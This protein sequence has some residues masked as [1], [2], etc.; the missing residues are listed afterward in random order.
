MS[1]VIIKAVF[2]AKASDIVFFPVVYSAKQA[3][4]VSPV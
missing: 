4:N 1:Y 2:M 3:W